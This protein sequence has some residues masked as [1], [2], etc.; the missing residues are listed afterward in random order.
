MQRL[1]PRA[2][3]STPRWC[4]SRPMPGS[5]AG[6]KPRS[7]PA[8]RAT[9]TA[10]CAMINQEF[11]PAP[12]RRGPARHHRASGSSCTTARAATMRSRA[13]TCS[14]R[15]AGAACRSRRC[16]ASTSRCGTSSASRS[17]RRCGSC[18]AGASAERMPAYA[19]G[20]WADAAQHR[21]AARGLRGQGRLQARVK[22]RIGVFDGSPAA[23]AERVI[24]A[25]AA[26][27]PEHRADVRCARHLHGVGGAGSSAIWCA[28]AASPGSR[29]R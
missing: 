21:R 3:P 23:S 14:R 11:A 22:M 20:G 29:S 10:W 15:S 26:L 18:S 17:A 12:G 9:T 27:G 8:A 4:A 1:R 7:R 19:S 6:A 2:P 25:R 5:P 16:R 28:T 24:A 13:A